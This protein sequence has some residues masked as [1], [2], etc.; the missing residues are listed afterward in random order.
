MEA[1]A[2]E[3]RLAGR[4]VLEERIGA[5]GMAAVWRAH[6]EVLARD[7]A[8][9]IL[10]GDLAAD[11]TFL[12]R[13]QREA[14]AAARLTHPDIVSVFDTGT[15]GGVCFIVMEHFA[16]ETLRELLRRTKRLEPS[17]AVAIL[18]PVLSALEAAHG[19][20]LVHR[21]ISLDNILIRTDEDGR[22]RVKV[23]DFGLAKAAGSTN[24]TATGIVVGTVRYLSPEQ[25]QGEEA[26]PASDLYSAGCVLYEMVTGR[27]PFQAETDLATAMMRL[28][29]D[30]VPPRDLVGGISR[31]LE[32]ALLRAMARRPSGRF[33][34]AA[35]MADALARHGE[36]NTAPTPVV[37]VGRG[38]E[39][40]PARAAA[41][42]RAAS[43][44]RSW[45]LLPVLLVVAAALVIVVGLAL[46]AFEL[47]GPL[48]VRPA[49]PA[50]AETPAAALRSIP[51]ASVRDYDPVAD[52]GDGSEHH[53]EV[54]LITDGDPSTAWT[55]SHYSTAGFGNLKDGLGLW[56]DFGRPVTVRRLV[57]STPV[58]GWAFQVRAGTSPA[59]V[60]TIR[61]SDGTE[62][63]TAS[64]RGRV[65][66]DLRPVVA[67]G[68]LIWI[69]RL[70][71]SG[72]GFEAAVAEVEAFGISA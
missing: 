69:T 15:D 30:P 34:S 35:A 57:V 40:A 61:G 67:R 52:G 47:G 38:G 51:I 7:V 12:E 46:G 55:T 21:D 54:G 42:P 72:G 37:R 4:Y 43:T 17:D 48:G 22:R 62:D 9:K 6:D 44:F 10:R 5:G 19:A 36:P 18:L 70:G 20:G 66:V 2:P 45:M 41:P 28:T 49:Q 13:F 53:E 16:A 39:P 26:T 59:D 1:I 33:P 60:T 50:P 29:H 8:V 65:V 64:H 25:V 23:T 32:A 58:A 11:P 24:L 27:P 31:G 56:V 3:R 63:F 71:P 68:V 14:V